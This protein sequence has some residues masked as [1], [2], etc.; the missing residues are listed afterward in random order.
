M[1][2]TA[3]SFFSQKYVIL[4]L[5]IMHL[6]VKL[7]LTIYLLFNVIKFKIWIQSCSN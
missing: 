7:Y 3:Q 2:Q 4:N 6:V 5:K 1:P